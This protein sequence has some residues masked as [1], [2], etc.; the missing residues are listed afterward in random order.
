MLLKKIA[1]TNDG[2]LLT[3]FGLEHGVS[4]QVGQEIIAS[5]Y[6]NRRNYTKWDAVLKN[7]IN[8][9][10]IEQKNKDVYALTNLGYKYVDEYGDM[11]KMGLCGET[12][13]MPESQNTSVHINNKKSSS[14]LEGRISESGQVMADILGAIRTNL[15]N[16]F[17][18]RILYVSNSVADNE[19]DLLRTDYKK[20][21]DTNEVGI[22]TSNH[23]VIYRLCGIAI[24][25]RKVDEFWNQNVVVS[26]RVGDV[27]IESI[28][29][30]DNWKSKS[31]ANNV[32]SAEE[33]ECTIWFK[34][35]SD[36]D[37]LCKVQVLL[38]EEY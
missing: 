14:A 12:F 2:I 26:A 18:K 21:V 13:L 29:T 24:F 5:E 27:L 31:Y 1:A 20:F 15:E 30:F 34:I 11:K 4:I 32:L 36:K 33:Y 10:Y 38:I 25:K 17:E 16:S 8:L 22:D 3:P 6:P 37:N 23:K 9:G 19:V 28:T 7:C 35:L